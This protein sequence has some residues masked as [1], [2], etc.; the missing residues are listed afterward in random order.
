MTRPR[1]HSGGFTIIELMVTIAVVSVL[2]GLAVPAFNDLIRNNRLSEQA[3][4]IVGAL[5]YARAETAVRG[6]PVSVCAANASRNACVAAAETAT[7]WANGWIIFT[8]RTGDLGVIDGDDTVLQTGAAP[9]MAYAVTN[10]ASFVRFGVGAAPATER[11]FTIAPTTTGLCNATGRRRVTVSMT[12]RVI[13]SKI[14][15]S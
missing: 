12:G 4:A 5:N 2:L 8:D 3:N 14:T 10:T 9:G 15:C 11:T 7:T 1:S 6:T 13:T